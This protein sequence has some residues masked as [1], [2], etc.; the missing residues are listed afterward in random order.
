MTQHSTLDDRI[1]NKKFLR[2]PKL[3][4]KKVTW[5]ALKSYTSIKKKKSTVKAQDQFSAFGKDQRVL[6]ICKFSI[7][8]KKV[9]AILVS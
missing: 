8:F 7:S 2:R 3:S 9:K 4:K 6:I 1:R 5:R